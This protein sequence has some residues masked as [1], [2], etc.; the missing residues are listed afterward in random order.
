MT[1]L[2][3]FRL[4]LRRDLLGTRKPKG[5]VLHR[6]RGPSLPLEVHA[7]GNYTVVTVPGLDLWGI[8]ELY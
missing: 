6:P 1:P 8:V 7:D 4:R 5:A 2:A 3:G